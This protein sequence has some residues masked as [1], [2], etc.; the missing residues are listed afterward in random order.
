MDDFNG[1]YT[2]LRLNVQDL[3]GWKTLGEYVGA[4]F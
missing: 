4:S 3:Q 1:E 2:I